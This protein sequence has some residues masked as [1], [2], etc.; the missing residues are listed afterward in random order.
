M[1]K[2]HSNQSI[3]FSS[4]KQNQNVGIKKN[5]KSKCIHWLFTAI[6]D[7]NQNLE[8][9]NPIKKRSMLIAFHDMIADMEPN[10][11]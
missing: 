8:D 11:K 3:N 4:T 10:K 5:K 2:I 6:D 1:S 7:V 9:Y